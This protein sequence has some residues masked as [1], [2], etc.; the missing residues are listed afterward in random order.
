MTVARDAQRRRGA[1]L[2]ASW[3]RA[4]IRDLEDRYAAGARELERA[5]RRGLEAVRRA[6][7]VHRVPRG[8]SQRGR[9][10]RRLRCARSCSRSRSPP[11]WEQLRAAPAATA[12]STCAPR[13]DDG[14]HR[15]AQRRSAHRSGEARRSLRRAGCRAPAPMAPTMMR[16]RTA[17][18]S[19]CR[20]RSRRRRRRGPSRR[21][22][23]GRRCRAGARSTSGA[24]DRRARRRSAGDARTSP[25]SATLA[26]ELEA[27]GDAAAS[28]SS[29]IRAAAPAARRVG[30]GRRARSA[31][32]RPRRGGRALV[33]QLSRRARRRPRSRPRRSRSRPSSR[34]SRAGRPP[35]PAPK[36][37]RVR[38]L[39]VVRER[40]APRGSWSLACVAPESRPRRHAPP[41]AT[42][43]VADAARA[44]DAA[45]RRHRCRADRCADRRAAASTIVDAPMAW[46]DERAQ[47]TLDV[48]ARAQRSRRGRSDDRRRA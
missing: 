32:R 43:H 1:W 27:G 15:V 16:R 9:Q 2:A 29:A 28:T 13:G 7:A 3:A 25:S 47:L 6:V 14:G 22:P 8:R 41:V 36:P 38:V 5:D 17:P 18:A 12:V 37:G 40:E 11:G 46:S 44:I 19:R 20:R 10:P 45:G 33:E 48:P 30:R 42:P 34:R 23:A 35:P 31:V 39:E 24:R 21:A 26:R 4:H